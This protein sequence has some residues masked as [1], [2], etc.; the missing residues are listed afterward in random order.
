MH[1]PDNVVFATRQYVDINKMRVA[2]GSRP[3]P[4]EAAEEGIAET[5]GI[6][7]LLP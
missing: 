4:T 5:R 2:G 6:L 7:L 3:V 1:M